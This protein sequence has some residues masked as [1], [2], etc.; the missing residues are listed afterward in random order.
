MTIYIRQG[1]ILFEKIDIQKGGEKLETK[2]V[3]LG[4]VTNHSHSFGKKDQVLL[5][6]EIDSNDVPTGLSVLE[7]TAELTHQEHL[8]IQFPKGEYRIR[9]ERS[10]NPFLQ[11]IQESMD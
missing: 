8:S 11:K 3:A 10:Y 9:R 6:K 1:D 7:E 5:Y 4:E 2:T